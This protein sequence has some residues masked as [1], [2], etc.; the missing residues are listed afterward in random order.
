MDI[1]LDDDDILPVHVVAKKP[2]E[3]EKYRENQV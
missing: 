1:M 2:L 3:K